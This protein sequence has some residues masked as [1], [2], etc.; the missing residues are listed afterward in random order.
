MPTSIAH[1]YAK[2]ARTMDINYL[3][4]PLKEAKAARVAAADTSLSH[5]DAECRDAEMQT[6]TP[7]LCRS[8]TSHMY[9][10]TYVPCRAGTIHIC[11]FFSH[12]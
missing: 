8:E 10:G 12:K 4:K 2:P 9:R 1:L 5:S 11:S 7:G 3:G 6:G